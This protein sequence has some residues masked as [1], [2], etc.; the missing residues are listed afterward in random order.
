MKL[1]LCLLVDNGSLQP[2][3]IFSLRIVA[4]KLSSLTPFSV[5]PLGLLHS[6]KIEP[7][8]LG[9]EPGGTISTFLSS[10][11]AEAE[12]E[13]LILPFFLGPSLGVTGWL[14]EKLE[15]W[16][17]EKKGRSYRVLNCL[18][19]NGEDRLAKALHE[20]IGKICKSRG[21]INP[22][23][24]MVDHGTPVQD[25]NRVRENVGISLHG[26]LSAGASKFSTCSMERRD[27]EKYAFNDP[28]LEQVLD[29][30]GLDG[31]GEVVVA[32]FFLM[33]GRH[34]GEGGDLAKICESAEKRFPNMKIFRTQPLG[35][36][37]LVL[38]ILK[39]RLESIKDV[40]DL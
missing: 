26:L 5:V 29:K 24:A 40:Y 39:D 17:T 7:R 22:S 12:D 11:L 35:G 25:V 14:I 32:L 4:K 37:Q 28:L 19:D 16:R 33:S 34:A 21:L 31:C 3:A 23:V 10:E 1:P 2:E 30:W 9:G 8:Q 38:S 6:N 36:H 15:G 18:H 13:L 27:G 20:E